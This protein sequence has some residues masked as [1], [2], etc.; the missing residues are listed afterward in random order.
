MKSLVVAAAI[1]AFSICTTAFG[2]A[3][4][5]GI[6]GTVSDPS[7]G[8]V[9][10]AKVAVY[11][12]DQARDVRS[13]TTGKDGNYALPELA[14]GKYRLSVEAKSFKKAVRD[15]IVL[16]VGDSL[17]LNVTLEIGDASQTVTVQEA[18][19]QVELQSGAQISTVTGDQLREL[20]LVTR[21]YEQMVG[22]LPGVSSANTDQLYVGNSL[23][24]GQANTIPFSINGV[25]SS[26][27]AWLVDG[28]DNVDRGS[29][30]TLLNTPSIDAIAE[31]KVQRSSYSAELGRAAGGQISVITKS[32]TSRFHGDVYEF[33]RNN[34]FAANNFLNNANKVNLGADGRA[35]VPPLRW[36]NFGWT[37]GG[38]LYIPKVLEK[39]KQNT[40]FFF[41]EEFRRTITYSTAV[42]TV[43][44]SAE[45]AG[46]FPHPVCTSYNGNTCLT[47]ATQ[48][49]TTSPLAQ[50]YIK[51]VFSRMSLPAAGN[52]ITS[53]FRNVYNFEQELYKIDH[54]FGAKLQLSAR[55][56]RDQIPTVEPQG[57]F[58]LGVAIP[59]VGVTSTNS[60]GH[61]W[62]A[63][64]VSTFT[65]TLLNEGG[66]AYSFGAIVSDPTGYMGLKNSPDIKPNLPFPVTLPLAPTLSFT[67]G[68]TLA[69]FGPYRDYNRNYNAFDNVTKIH[70]NHT[71][72]TGFAVNHYQKRENAASGN[73]GSFAFTTS[74]AQLPA[75]GATTIEQSFANFLLGSVAAFSQ[76]SLDLT[77]DI[78]AN[79]VEYYFQD[80]WRI[81]PNLTLNAGVRHSIY[82]QPYDNNGKLTTFDPLFYNPANAPQMTAAGN[83][84]P[85]TGDPLNG[86][87]IGGR[88]SRYTNKISPENGLNI[89]PRLSLAWDP[90]GKG[91]T[92][93]RSGYG[94]FY[95][96][97]LVGIY[98]QDIFANPPFVNSVSIPNVTLDNPGAG[99]ATVSTAPKIIRGVSS[100]YK[101]PYTQQWNLDI[102]HEFR[103]SIVLD[104]AYVGTKGTHLL[105][106]VELNEVYPG[107][108]YSSGLIAA[109]TTITSANTPVLNLLRPYRG[110]SAINIIEPWFNSSYNA[111]QTTVQKRF[112]GATM[113]SA[114]YTWAH[115]L[116]DNQTDRSSAPQ[117]TY[118]FNKGEYGPTQYDR[119]QVFNATWVYEIPFLK[120]GRGPVGMALGGWQA[121]GVVTAY[122]GLPLTVI[123]SGIDTGGLA[124]LP[125]AASA[126]PDAICNPNFG[127][128]GD[129]FQYFNTACFATPAIGKVGNEGRGVVYGPGFQRW[130]LS[131]SKNV[132]FGE[133]YRLQIRG[134]ATNLFN[135]ANP[136]A[137]GTTSTTTSTF[138]Q[139][140]SYRDPR[141]LQL[142]AKF[143]F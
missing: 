124:I 15:A 63:H 61:N 117:N 142:A 60:P 32:G 82:R 44:T 68:S 67:G 9:A 45:I 103:K 5:A 1:V 6:V 49:N 113:I 46:T 130:D 33:A 52:S 96:S 42:G 131:L 55:F 48:I 47:T 43:P 83:L 84:V 114:N 54:N 53:L 70:G 69:G 41:S 107:L 50:A 34:A 109:G 7:G 11:S 129:R 81:K 25:R 116:T 62:T 51:D 79:Q 65:P 125:G 127:S 16:N 137:L 72:R 118:N 97:T 10:A 95:D 75:G 58:S 2:Q 101:T 18:P 17:T 105:G 29:N 22:L 19:L 26:S 139:V 88:N 87:S 85:G 136:S 120:Q 37:L 12:I 64:A 21:N 112:S 126:R 138:G 39:A 76:T 86:I 38:P 100:N 13:V 104:V 80:D 89:A 73:Q 56:L 132:R 4:N 24:S 134:E 141:I 59:N 36:N 140:T 94:I 108:A 3:I 135:H 77:P 90:F 66:F 123:T 143:Y 8:V 28:A 20:G 27:S 93:I 78:R 71:F 92:A 111:L 74:T 110:Y 91:T 40:F 106:I 23:P 57:L 31:F 133:N 121:A 102:Q 115:G 14:A 122:T 119:R 99:A 128:T 35:Q 30:L 98:E